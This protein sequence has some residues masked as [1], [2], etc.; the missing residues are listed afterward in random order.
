MKMKKQRY[1]RRSSVGSETEGR[2]FVCRCS[3]VEM[4]NPQWWH[5]TRSA[6]KLTA[7]FTSSLRYA[8]VRHAHY[9]RTADV[10]TSTAVKTKKRGK[11]I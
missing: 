10:A 8:H 7:G 2:S 3:I 1:A 5:G 4:Q 11:T 6:F 9:F